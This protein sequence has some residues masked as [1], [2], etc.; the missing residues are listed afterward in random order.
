MPKKSKIN[1]LKNMNKE[2]LK[3]AIS[4]YVGPHRTYQR[5]IAMQLIIDGNTHKQV[6]ETLGVTYATINRWAKKCEKEGIEGLIPNFGGGRPSYLTDE[7]KEELNAFIQEQDYLDYKD[8]HE[9]ILRKYEVNYSMKQIGVLRKEL[10][11]N[12]PRR[13]P[14]FKQSPPNA[15]EEIKKKSKN[16]K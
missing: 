14:I 16:Q 4:K 2:E 7:Q 15:D 1:V 6:A 12:Y 11:Y 9:L 10:G 8:L 5:L 3:K 13:Y